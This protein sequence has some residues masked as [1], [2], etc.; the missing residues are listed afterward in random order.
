MI[1]NYTATDHQPDSSELLSS[2]K[3]GDLL[4]IYI[5]SFNNYTYVC[6][7]VEQLRSLHCQNLII[8]DNASTYPPLLQYFERIK[9]EVAIVRLTENYGPYVLF[10]NPTL[11][12][13]LPPYFGVTDPD[14]ELNPDL[15]DDFIIQLL[16]LT[17]EFHV[18]KA[19][20]SLDIS[21]PERMVDRDF[22]INDKHYKIW[23]WEARFWRHELRPN[24]YKANLDTTFAIY[25][26]QYLDPQNHTSN[27]IRVAGNFTCRHLPWYR[28]NGLPKAEE[29]FYRSQSC[30][31]YYLGEKGE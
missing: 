14:L 25:N 24:V 3:A 10:E 29:E 9:N 28:E 13:F 23:E 19:G 6:N 2:P 5:L 21:E 8:I 30:Y 4:P 16:Q 18:G 1:P 17:E 31:S 7:M 15:P 22:F 11:Y 12:A 26:K 20:F 27:A